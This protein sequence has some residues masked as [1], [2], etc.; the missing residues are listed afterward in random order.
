[1]ASTVVQRND[2]EIR[3]APPTPFRESVGLF[4]LSSLFARKLDYTIWTA[5]YTLL[6]HV[7]EP[8]LKFRVS[9]MAFRASSSL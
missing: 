3:K 4:F 2:A 9:S 7:C 5:K 1:M 8:L 6:L